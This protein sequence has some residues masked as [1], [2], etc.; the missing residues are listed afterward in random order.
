MGPVISD[1][2]VVLALDG[3]NSKTDVAVVAADGTV[4]ATVR[5]AGYRPHGRSLGAAVDVLEG[6]VRE[7]V[8]AAGIA[9]PVGHVSACV[10]NADL[11]VEEDRLRD[12]LQARGWAVTTAVANDTFA[13]LR[14]GTAAADAVGVVCGAG[15]N[16]VGRRGGG[17]TVRFPALGRITG[18]WGGG[19]G[20]FEEVMWWSVRAE[21]GRGPATALAEAAAAH[22]GVATATQVAIDVHLGLIGWERL[23]ELVPLLCRVA[24]EG[25]EVA[26]RILDRQAEEVAVLATTALR[27]LDLLGRVAD[28][29][30]GGGV[31]AARP[32]RLIDGIGLRL[33]DAAPHARIRIADVPPIAGAALLGLE[34]LHGN[35]PGAL[36]EAER[37]LR[38]AFTGAGR[39]GVGL[40]R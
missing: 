40:V 23:H 39:T 5:G 34:T 37:R 14:S 19:G 10:A 33:A 17:G 20:L 4:L 11:P 3:G 22:F 6:L 9:L 31:L 24:D 38:G 30:L 26:A 18:D 16:C 32:R 21:D 12:E 13:V 36:A 27:R 29:A 35:A 15:I 8:G 2:R 25:D 1:R 7:A 28:V